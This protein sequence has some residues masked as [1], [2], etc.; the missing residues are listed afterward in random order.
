M[1]PH[2]WWDHDIDL[3]YRQNMMIFV[4][5]NADGVNEAVVGKLRSMET[6]IYDIAHPEFLEART[7]AWRYWMDKVE[8]FE[9][10]HTLM[11]KL[12]KKVWARY[13]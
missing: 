3:D 2:F 1:R 4:K 12:L 8:Q 11:A 5:Q 7:K 9:T 10:R 13:K 6:H